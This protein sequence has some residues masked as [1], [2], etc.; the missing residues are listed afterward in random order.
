MIG[1]E[2]LIAE[3]RAAADP[4]PVWVDE[5]G[6]DC[7]HGESEADADLVTVGAHRYPGY[8]GGC[9][10]PVFRMAGTDHYDYGQRGGPGWRWCR[11]NC[12]H[13][14]REKFR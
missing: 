9:S 11:D 14:H 2:N 10:Q 8:S 5:G 7:P 4:N 6:R 13:G 1:L 12:E 3:A